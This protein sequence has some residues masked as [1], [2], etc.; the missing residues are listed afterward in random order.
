VKGLS[1]LGST[2]SIGRQALDIVAHHPDRLRVVAL[3]AGR[4][5]DLL[6]EQ[7]H[8]FHPR[9]VAIAEPSLEKA[10]RDRLH[11]PACEVLSGPQGLEAAAAAAD[12][13]LVLAG[14]VG[15]AGL[16]PT[17]AAVDAGKE[18][19][20]A[21]KEVLVAAGALVTARATAAGAT[22]LPVDSEHSAIFQCLQGQQR[23]AVRRI[24][25]TASG[26]PFSRLS[27]QELESVSPAQ[28][29]NH[30][31]WRMGD[32]VTVDSATLMNK[33]LEIIEARW[34]F[35]IPPEKIDVVIHHQSIVHSLVEFDDG[36][37]IAQLGWP[38]MT[39]PI[40]YGLLYPD[41]ASTST[42]PLDLARVSSLTFAQPDFGK[43]PA[44]ALARQALERGQNY[45][46]A[47]SAANEIAVAAF[48]ER[49]IGFT[50][51][52]RVAEY[53]MENHQP[54]LDTDLRAILHA[55]AAGR[56]AATRW[57]RE[58]RASPAG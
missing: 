34:L 51:I 40:Q 4:N 32:K 30:P 49:Q 55:D 47:L 54:S 31:T 20:L 15:S 46:A 12:A 6:V 23:H 28:A 53:A 8:R 58:Q 41:R 27:A 7:A 35:D 50:Q 33:G 3:A 25:L 5:V 43:F 42:E 48:L 21:N 29:L 57:I 24:I 18:V 13:N 56:H 45:P 2:G 9:I 19:A 11:V 16:L 22:L 44:L 37:V 39:L 38:S 10:L 1:I 17:L 26:G 52:P 14:M 36:S